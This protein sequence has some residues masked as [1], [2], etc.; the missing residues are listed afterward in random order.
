MDSGSDKRD[1]PM[2]DPIRVSFE[3]NGRR[4]EVSVPPN[5]M[6]SDLLRERF[7]LTSVKISCD[8][9][10]CGACTVLI[11]G[12]PAIGC[13]TFAFEA[14]DKSITTIEGLELE[15]GGLHPVQQAFL[16]HGAI[17]CGYC[18]PGIVLSVVALLNIHPNP[19]RTAIQQWLGAHVC[20]CTGYQMIVEAVV[21]AVQATRKRDDGHTESM[22]PS[23][24]SVRVDGIEKVT[25]QAEYTT[26]LY[27]PGMLHGKILRSPHAHARIRRID[28]ERAR[29]LPGVA[30]V[31]T[32]DD[33]LGMDSTYGFIVRDQPVL[34]I[35]KVRYVGDTVAAV[36][37]EDEA[38]AFQ[39]LSLID[40]EYE[41]LP[42]VMTMEDA[43]ADDA[44]LLFETPQ[45]RV[46]ELM[47]SAAQM[48][49]EPAPNVLFEYTYKKS[50]EE[51]I[52][53]LFRRCDHVYEDTYTTN[54]VH[55][56]FLEPYV[57]VAHVKRGRIE[58]WACNQDPFEL[59]S[60][61][62]RMF[63]VTE[64]HVRIHTNY[65][66]GGFGGKSFCKME[67]V[68]VLL[69]TKVD[70]PV[71]LCLSMDE[72]FHTLCKPAL[73][74]TLKTGVMADGTLV[75]RASEIL[76]NGGAYSDA[77]A[78]M[79]IKAG[80][81]I[82]GPYRWQALDTRA[83]CVRTNTVPAGSF[84]GFGGTQATFASES[85]IEAIAQ[86]LGIDPFEFRMKNFL[87]IGEPFLPND[88][89]VDSDLRDGL[90]IVAERLGYSRRKRVAGR[91]MGLSVGWK[92]G[93][94]SG[95]LHGQAAVKVTADGSI[96]V[97][98]GTVEIGQ[99]AATAMCTIAAKVLNAPI[100]AVR[101]AKIDTDHTPLDPGT[102]GSSGIVHVGKAVELAALDVLRQVLELAMAKRRS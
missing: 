89:P 54:K 67:P 76:V 97:N 80:Y 23:S 93:A 77:N 42:S 13:M 52:D 101:Y 27:V 92:D 31:V 47:P 6:L 4:Y 70:R 85:Q 21:S 60:D 79:A 61:L 17:Q 24:H 91:G 68:A 94:T 20:R 72:A 45:P 73:R 96:I 29:A 55:H 58:V 66:G 102:R 2:S 99:G 83:R 88:R 39:A 51:S 1:T 50:G 14:H 7:N 64:G 33:L 81:R 41:V 43:L 40:V 95:G 84:R 44:P 56:Y 82:G 25:G 62:S 35:D 8:Q 100:E 86:R 49:I 30:S 98:A 71:R 22:Q 38:T 15:D 87:Q 28:S 36:V 90:R 18:T 19:D 37:A 59:R 26:D 34:A 74:I 3:I 53:E 65:V 63:G 46:K 57:T 12:K 16:T 9:G 32:R 48:F 10:V 75:A 5:V 11:D 69:A 78:A